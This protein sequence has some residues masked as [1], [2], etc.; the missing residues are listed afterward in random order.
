MTAIEHGVFTDTTKERLLELE[1]EQSTLNNQLLLE[2]S[3]ITEFKR[4]DIISSLETFRDGD[5]DNKQYQADLFK[6][7]LS[8]VYLYDDDMEIVFDFSG[9]RNKIRHPLNSE[10]EPEADN[11]ESAEVSACSHK[12]SFGSPNNAKFERAKVRMA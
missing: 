6:T 7:F 8:A 9:K 1:S 2:R 11:T 10:P 12:L 5:I 4:E 3:A